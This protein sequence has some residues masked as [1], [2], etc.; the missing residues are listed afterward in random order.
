VSGRVAVRP[1]HRRPPRIVLG[2][3]RCGGYVQGMRDLPTV[4]SL[5][6]LVD[7]LGSRRDLYLRWSKD[8][9]AD[10]SQ[11]SRDDL[12]GVELPGLS[13][14]SLQVESWWRSRPRR[15]WVAR[16]IYDYE[17]LQRRKPGARPWL[18]SGRECGRGPDNE[19]LVEKA[20]PVAWISER[21]VDEARAEVDAVRQDWGSLDRRDVG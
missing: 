17:H 12:T 16:R 21:V 18:L 8:P 20:Q 10:L 9:A 15:L 4:D 13:V 3:G 14:N 7:L 1:R 11:A 19:P 2:S 5:H 6:E